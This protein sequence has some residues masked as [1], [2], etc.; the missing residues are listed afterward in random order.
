MS[1]AIDGLVSGLD[2]TS[3][4]NSLMQIEG[5]PQTLLKNKV[6]DSQTY[7]TALRALNTKVAS[8]A[9]L[10]T[11]MATAGS[12]DLYSAT[13]SS[14]TVT[15][16]TA[17]GASAGQL[18]FVVDRLAQAQKS[19]SAAMVS[20][21]DSPPVLTIVGSDGVATEVTAS[22]TSLSDVVTAVNRAGAGVVA[23][24]VSIGGGESRIQ[25]TAAD[26]GVAGSFTV[27]Q[28][29]GTAT[30]LP[31]TQI[32]GAQ[33][34]ALTLWAGTAAAATI[35]SPRNTFDNLLPGVSATVSAVSAESIT[36]SVAQDD[37]RIGKLAGELVSALSDI[38][39]LIAAKSA[40][41]T[42]ADSTGTTR[43]TGGPFTGESTVRDVNRQILDAATLPVNG[44]S[45]SEIGISIT[46]TGTVTFDAEK[47]GSALAKDPAATRGM[48][49]EVASRVAAAATSV[50]D[51]YEGQLSRKIASQDSAVR[52]LGLQ[53]DDWDRRLE[54]RR[55]TLE[56]TY[57]ALE[58]RLN[59][60]NTQQGWL[61]SQLASLPTWSSS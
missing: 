25:F 18:A 33:D 6:F 59:S 8:L 5:N 3:L 19:V 1:L 60:L 50:S 52:E 4:I 11:K 38:F 27:Y 22:S 61:T 44:R 17:S 15:V 35:T 45:P 54:S 37:Q 10:T 32:Q 12:L 47:F 13:S 51:K 49:Q 56:R 48:L 41:A 58:V 14:P 28:G 23:T 16:T 7:V 34:A 46:K 43:T 55:A 53:I 31:V 36:V 29:S 21:P 42:G 57:S 20:W 40:V 30:P 24:L 26:T 9:E 2:T 39:A